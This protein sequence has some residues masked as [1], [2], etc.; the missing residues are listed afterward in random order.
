MS[1]K[2]N[3]KRDTTNVTCSVPEGFEYNKGYSLDDLVT[4]SK[5]YWETNRNTSEHTTNK[6]NPN[7]SWHLDKVIEKI[8]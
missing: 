2:Q 5:Y 4:K 6:I 8:S 3:K 1:K 7:F